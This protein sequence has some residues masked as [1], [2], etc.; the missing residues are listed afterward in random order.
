VIIPGV[1]AEAK[2]SPVKHPRWLSDV[3]PAHHTAEARTVLLTINKPGLFDHPPTA[4]D[5]ETT[6][7]GM[8]MVTPTC[9]IKIKTTITALATS[10]P[11]I[12]TTLAVN[13]K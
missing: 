11:T 3:K 8:D 4:Q 12:I 6:M 2:T 9:G 10:I 1:K 5:H 7:D 13:H